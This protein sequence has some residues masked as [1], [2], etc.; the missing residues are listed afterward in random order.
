MI[1]CGSVWPNVRPEGL[2]VCHPR[3]LYDAAF[4]L[5]FLLEYDVLGVA[6]RY[7]RSLQLHSARGARLGGGG[8]AVSACLDR[9]VRLVHLSRQKIFIQKIHFM[10]IDWRQEFLIYNKVTL[11]YAL[12]NFH[13]ENELFIWN[14]FTTAKNINILRW[15]S[16][17][18]LLVKIFFFLVQSSFNQ[19]SSLIYPS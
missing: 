5:G 15:K 16:K 9:T 1:L 8:A 17:D 11:L 2:E 7:C 3:L 19:N 4:T 14:Y 13:L 6:G 18:K 12:T 10:N